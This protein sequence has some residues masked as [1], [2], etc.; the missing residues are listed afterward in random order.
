MM[1]MR[2]I[3]HGDNFTIHRNIE[4]LCCSSKMNMKG[5]VNYASIKKKKMV[6]GRYALS[7]LL[8]KIKHWALPQGLQSPLPL[9]DV[10]DTYGLGRS[11]WDRPGAPHFSQAPRK[12]QFLQTP[13]CTLSSKVLKLLR[14]EISW[15]GFSGIQLHLWVQHR[16]F[17]GLHFWHCEIAAGWA[18][19]VFPLQRRGKW[20][21]SSDWRWCCFMFIHWSPQ[22][23]GAHQQRPSEIKA[24]R[25]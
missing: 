1:D 18:E 8:R 16:G 22:T 20:Q 3:Y 2:W 4:S 14:V 15:A 12:C 6:E 19:V 23:N 13:G 17:F 10:K 21:L 9:S 24:K 11:R 7:Q 25:P 5:Y